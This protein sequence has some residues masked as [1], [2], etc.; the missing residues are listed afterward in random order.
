[1]AEKRFIFTIVCNGD[2]DYSSVSKI[3][4]KVDTNFDGESIAVSLEGRPDDVIA[5]NHINYYPREEEVSAD[6]YDGQH[7]F[8]GQA[9]ADNGDLFF[10]ESNDL[11]DG[12]GPRKALKEFF[13]KIVA[14]EFGENW[15]W[16]I[17]PL[18]G[19]TGESAAISTG[20]AGE[21]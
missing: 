5:L 11:Q 12:D 20:G 15:T 7:I 13:S 4:E 8:M 3:K 9:T 19:S 18:Q 21:G 17:K 1:M 14:N 16:M 6:G 2:E 10:K